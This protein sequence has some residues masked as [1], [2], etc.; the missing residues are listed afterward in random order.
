MID[1]K[2]HKIS[3]SKKYSGMKAKLTIAD[4]ALNGI[5]LV[6]FQLHLSEILQLTALSRFAN[7]YAGCL[8]FSFMFLAYLYI[9][10]FPIHFYSTYILEHDYDLSRQ[11]IGAWSLDELKSTG[12]SLVLMLLGIELFYFVLRVFPSVW[13]IV[14]AAIWILFSIILTKFLPSLLIPLFYKYT[15]LK[16]GFLKENILK[17]ARNAAIELFDVSVIDF[18]RKTRKA[19]AAL[20]GLGSTRKVILADTL[21]DKFTQE[22][23]LAVV[24]HEFG[25]LKFKHI[26]KL[27]GMTSFITITGFYILFKFS[28]RFLVSSGA[29][30]IAELKY[31]PIFMLFLFIFSLILVPAQNFFSRCLERQADKFALEATQ[32]P[33]SF[34]RVMDKL[35]E[36]N[37]SDRDPS[38][39]K[40]IFAYDH[41]PISERVQMALAWKQSK[42]DNSPKAS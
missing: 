22:E 31:L 4:I 3:V 41:P 32:D 23:V 38:F 35:A 7:F 21:V 9:G 16:T 14:F 30:T 2:N 25:H 5:L 12:L 42:E 8:V 29:N 18:S 26:W 40:K 20:V 34:I 28:G 15:P 37:L 36:M 1:N 10:T 19:N 27:L 11:S 17:L 39:L 13:W 6:L 33:D 24:A